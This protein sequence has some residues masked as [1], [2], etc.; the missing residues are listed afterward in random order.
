MEYTSLTKKIVPARSV[1][2][3]CGPGCKF[4]CEEKIS[5]SSRI[6]FFT[7]FWSITD[8]SKKYVFL[9]R[10]ASEKCNEENVDEVK[11]RKSMVY[12]INERG[13]HIIVCK[14]MF[15]NKLNI[16]GQMLDTAFQ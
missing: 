13:K 1:Q 14:S 4:K 6:A 11:K 2:R 16:S 5:E 3:I 7:E 10:H 12:I 15:I 8:H 9:L